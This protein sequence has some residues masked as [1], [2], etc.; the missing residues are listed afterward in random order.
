MASVGLTSKA[1]GQVRRGNLAPLTSSVGLK[2]VMAV[3]GFVWVGFLVGHLGTNAHLFG[4][5]ESLNDYYASLK[6]NAVLFWGVRVVLATSIAAHIAAATIL[7]RRSNAARGVG[8]RVRQYRTSS[9]AGRTMPWT[10]VVVALFIL[11]HLLHFT[12]GQAMP[13]GTTFIEGDD[14]SNIVS[15]FSIS[16]VALIY[17]ACLVLL[18]FHLWHGAFAATLSLGLRHPR[19]T[20]AVRL[21]VGALVAGLLAGMLSMPIS[22]LAGLV[23]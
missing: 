14:Y 15:S 11:Y 19:Y 6:A 23:R 3:S 16:Y 5:P 7:T 21:A 18:G 22:V 1:G 17:I 2:A 8:Y 4:G 20:R 13:A 9:F 12:T 10:G